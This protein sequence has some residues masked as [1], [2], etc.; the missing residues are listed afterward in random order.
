MGIFNFGFL[1]KEKR[2]FEPVGEKD[3][4]AKIFGLDSDKTTI[5]RS[6]VMQIPALK[7]GI[8]Y[9]ADLVSSL[10]IK[11][12]KEV[13]GKVET[14]SD[15]YRLRLLNDETGDLLNS[16]Q[17]KQSLV[18]DFILSGN[19][20][21]YIN[22]DG[23]SIVSLHYIKPSLVSVVAGVDPI[24]KDGK[25]FVN[26]EEYE[27]YDF[28]IFAQNTQDGLTGKGLLDESRDL[29]ELA[30]NTLAFANNNIKAGGIKRGVVKSTKK[31]SQEAMTFLKKSWGEL[32]DNTSNKN[33][34]V[35]ILNDGLDFQ[36]LSQT[37]IELQVL[38]NRK[39]N[40]NDILN[41]I[42]IPLNILNGTATEQQYNNFI[43]STIIPILS[44]LESAFNS[45]LLLET[46]K[47]DGYYFAFS[48]KD[49]LKGNTLERFNTYKTAID[50]GVMTINECRYQENLDQ[51][52]NMDILKMSLGN[53][54]YNIETGETYVPNTGQIVNGTNGVNNSNLKQ[55]KTEPTDSV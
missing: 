5:T 42:K 54:I 2:G 46:E 1:G 16:F 29:L 9:I 26:G 22:K 10:E 40:D 14:I 37:S 21:L 12:Y 8:C 17:M 20:Y 15:D 6:M 36:E 31:L 49:L 47:A 53:I 38:E 3:D 51:I 41:L 13:D 25:L 55:E 50:S 43:K 18:R 32:Y 11:L 7:A 44:Q 28:V 39:V 52:P 23:T 48:V 34:K 24:F 27:S 33:N 30:Y 4:L 19:G 35:I 45:A